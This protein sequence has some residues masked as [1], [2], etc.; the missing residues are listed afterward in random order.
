V[1]LVK[2]ALK[3]SSPGAVS[4]RQRTAEA[5]LSELWK[6][7]TALRLLDCAGLILDRLCRRDPGRPSLTQ[8]GRNPQPLHIP[9][10]HAA[11]V[12]RRVSRSPFTMPKE[13]IR[14][15]PPPRTP[16]HSVAAIAIMEPVIGRERTTNLSPQ[17]TQSPVFDADA[18][19]LLSRDSAEQY[20][21]S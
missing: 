8:P 14:W 18:S 9:P 15:Q 20:L 10:D 1:T 13:M 11:H 19:R 4:L 21:Y 12:F 16:L 2:E 6:C 17:S 3:A 5:S 7:A